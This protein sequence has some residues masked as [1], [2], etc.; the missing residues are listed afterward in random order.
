VAYL[1][2]MIVADYVRAEHGVLHMIAG[3]FDRIVAASVPAARNVGIG[4]RIMFTK[5]ECEYPHTL[6]IIFKDDQDDQDEHLATFNAEV[7]PTYREDVEY[8]GPEAEMGV[9]AALNV[10]VPLPRYGR[11]TLELRIDSILQ[12]N[13]PLIVVPFTAEPTRDG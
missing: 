13:I 10:G 4:L 1:D 2:Y 9:V 11:Y 6:E 3:G 12:K 5:S 8:P 7:K